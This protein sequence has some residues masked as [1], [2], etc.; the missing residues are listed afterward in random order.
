[1]LPYGELSRPQITALEILN[2]FH[3]CSHVGYVPGVHGSDYFESVP[4]I[5]SGDCSRHPLPLVIS[6]ACMSP[7]S[8]ST[9]FVCLLNHQKHA[10]S[11]KLLH[12]YM[13]SESV[14]LYTAG[15]PV[16]AASCRGRRVA[17]NFGDPL[18]C[19]IVN[20]SMQSLHCFTA[21]QHG[22]YWFDCPA[23][24]D[25]WLHLGGVVLQ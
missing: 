17:L 19:E 24:R 16:Y 8:P 11:M 7:I 14:N 12:D 15:T 10:L 18:N 25:T 22:A 5:P 2:G 4:R 1:M 13:A 9:S 3:G 23:Y 21:D 6:D 20:R